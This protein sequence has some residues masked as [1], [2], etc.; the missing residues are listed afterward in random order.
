MSET[1]RPERLDDEHLWGHYTAHSELA[2]L[3]RAIAERSL[4]EL[5]RR[6]LI[7]ESYPDDLS[8]QL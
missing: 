5:A 4:G 6:G 1:W 2:E 7:V 3:H 8:G